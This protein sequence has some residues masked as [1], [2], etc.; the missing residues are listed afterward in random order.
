[1]VPV[2]SESVYRIL[3]NLIT[4][5]KTPEVKNLGEELSKA[6]IVKDQDL[7]HKTVSLNSIVEFLD[8]SLSKPIRMQ[9]VLPGEADLSSKKVS[10]FAPISIALIGFKENDSFTWNMPSGLKTLKIIRVLNG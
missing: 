9:I 8:A 7:N 6:K 5:H 4:L 2:I 3:F 1:M 10:I